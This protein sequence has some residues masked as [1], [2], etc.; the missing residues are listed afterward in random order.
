MDP[1]QRSPCKGLVLPDSTIDD[2][3]SHSRFFL[4]SLPNIEMSKKSPFA[5]QK[6]LRGISG[7]P[8]S[9]RK[10]RSGDLLVETVSAVQSKSFLSAKTF[11]DSSLTVTIHKSLNSC[12]GVIS[13]VDLLCASE[14]EILEGLLPRVLSR[15]EEL[16]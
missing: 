3:A 5:I 8:K 9:V 14:A 16:H 6:A 10:L 13:E 12:R 15:S 1:M 4:L 11:L 2:I 7:D